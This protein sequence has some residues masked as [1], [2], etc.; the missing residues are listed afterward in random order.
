MEKM[1]KLVITIALLS[2]IPIVIAN[3][4]AIP[5]DLI[6][7]QKPIDAQC[8][9]DNLDNAK[10]INLNDCGLVKEKHVFKGHNSSLI[11]KNFIGYDWQVPQ[12]YDGAQGYSY[13]RYFNAGNQW[14]WI[15]TINSGGGSGNFTA[16][17]LVKRINA[18]TLQTRTI[19]SGDRCN[20][21]VQIEHRTEKKLTFSVNLT[22]YD[23]IAL[24]KNQD[25][26]IKAYND[27]AACAVCCVAKAFYE[28][29]IEARP[30]L[31]YVDLGNKRNSE[32]MPQQGTSQACFNKLLATYLNLGK[33]KL[34]H[35]ELTEFT[36][37]FN[38]LCVDVTP[39][40]TP[41]VAR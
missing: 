30:Q 32:E 27:L 20:G 18:D 9:F 23:F 19:A 22:A 26:S 7:N 6:F 4:A 1:S 15:Y 21:G 39:H 41:S 35:R 37:K 8:F 16:L 17:K 5:D 40:V 24:S 28:V 14:Y 13:Y 12:S 10:V 3:A 2:S 25:P 29:G 11:K 31:T 36:S 33:T 38:N 34:N